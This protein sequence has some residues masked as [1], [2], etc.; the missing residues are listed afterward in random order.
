MTESIDF[1]YIKLNDYEIRDL[2][3]RTDINSE[4]DF[5]YSRSVETLENEQNFDRSDLDFS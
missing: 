2:D 3:T 4:D 1:G 5:S